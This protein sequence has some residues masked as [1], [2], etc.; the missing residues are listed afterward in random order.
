MVRPM[1]DDQRFAE[2]GGV[3][4]IESGIP[5]PVFLAKPHHDDVGGGDGVACADGVQVRALVI[6]P[7]LVGFRP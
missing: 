4:G 5:L 1:H 2:R 7:E 6:M 3:A